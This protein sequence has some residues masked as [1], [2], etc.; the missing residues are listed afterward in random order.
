MR[1]SKFAEEGSISV[2]NKAVYRIAPTAW[3][4]FPACFLDFANNRFSHLNV[5]KDGAKQHCFDWDWNR[6]VTNANFIEILIRILIRP[7]VTDICCQK[8]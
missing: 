5:H 8:N 3:C 6:N 2:I 7:N 1:I 4:L